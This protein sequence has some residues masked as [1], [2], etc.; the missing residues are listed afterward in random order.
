MRADSGR[1]RAGRLPDSLIA[2]RSAMV[3]AAIDG[4]G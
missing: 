3:E 2:L 1:M 4:G